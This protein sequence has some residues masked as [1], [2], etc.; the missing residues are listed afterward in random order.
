[1][2]SPKAGLNPM[3]DTGGQVLL[4]IIM[5][6]GK[7]FSVIDLQ[8]FHELTFV[9]K[10]FLFFQLLRSMFNAKK[11]SNTTSGCGHRI[12]S[13]LRAF[14]HFTHVADKRHQPRTIVVAFWDRRRLHRISIDLQNTCISAR[15]P[16]DL[17]HS[18]DTP[19]IRKDWGCPNFRDPCTLDGYEKRPDDNGTT[20]SSTIE[21]TPDSFSFLQA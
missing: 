16:T 18:W 3:I 15:T 6:F 20:S 5:Q 9:T 4:G 13:P 10:Q 19:Y 7:N 8:G 17:W 12:L 2:L 1:M 21:K 14:V 11:A